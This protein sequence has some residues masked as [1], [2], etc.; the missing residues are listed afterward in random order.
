MSS[1]KKN[2]AGKFAIQLLEVKVLKFKERREWEEAWSNTAMDYTKNRIFID[3]RA[4]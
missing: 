4:F 3:E 1:L 2:V